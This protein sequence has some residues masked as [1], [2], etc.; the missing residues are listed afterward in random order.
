[1]KARLSSIALLMIASSL[2]LVPTALA[3]HD[4]FSASTFGATASGTVSSTQVSDWWR[5][6]VTLGSQTYTLYPFG[7][8]ADLY[9]YDFNCNQLLCSSAAG[10]TTVD[11]CTARNPGGLLDSNN[12]RIEVRYYSASDGTVDYTLTATWP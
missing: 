6:S 8:D 5:H 9:V 11:D 12:Q 3:S 1:M 10:G 2:P 7:G 4:C